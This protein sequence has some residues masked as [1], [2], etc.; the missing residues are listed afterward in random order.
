MFKDTVPCYSHMIQAE[1]G[2]G[3]AE[4]Q[5]SHHPQKKQ[6]TRNN[7]KA[8]GQEHT[9]KPGNCLTPVGILI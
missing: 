5:S 6:K 1:D 4:D 7:V 9:S 3:S 8:Q 2:S